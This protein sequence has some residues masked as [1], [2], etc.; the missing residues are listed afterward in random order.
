MT[1]LEAL[2]RV[3]TALSAEELAEFRAWLAEYEWQLWD[4]ELERDAAAG[5]LDDLVAEALS[6]VERGDT[7]DL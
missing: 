3:V 4:E 6:D 2:E 7:R 1:K 5:L